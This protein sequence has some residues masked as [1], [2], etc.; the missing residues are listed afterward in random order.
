MWKLFEVP[1]YIS[2]R[3]INS[4]KTEW[5]ILPPSSHKYVHRTYLAPASPSTTVTF[6]KNKSSYSPSN[7]TTSN[8]IY[9]TM[10]NC[11]FSEIEASA[12]TAPCRRMSESTAPRSGSTLSTTCVITGTDDRH[13]NVPIHRAAMCRTA[14]Y[15]CVRSR[16]SR[17]RQSF[18]TC[19][20]IQNDVQLHLITSHISP[21]TYG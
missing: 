8:T 18:S 20:S 12:S 10:L 17:G 4:I 11:S 3:S 5:K 9:G 21:C 1:S 2:L 6:S 13:A 14:R 7:G 19:P 15:G 16:H